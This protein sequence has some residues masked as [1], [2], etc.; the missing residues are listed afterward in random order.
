MDLCRLNRLLALIFMASVAAGCHADQ[1]NSGWSL[2][3]RM[4]A[5]DRLQR[6]GEVP[7]G[8]AYGTA[9]SPQ[10][11]IGV[12]DNKLLV[13]RDY[14]NA[15]ILAVDPAT[16]D[17]EV[18]EGVP[19][20]WDGEPLILG[21]YK[22]SAGGEWVWGDVGVALYRPDSAASWREAS[23]GFVKIE[24]VDGELFALGASEQWRACAPEPPIVY[25]HTLYRHEGGDRWTALREDV[26]AFSVVEEHLFIT[27]PSETGR[28]VLMS[29]DAGAHWTPSSNEFALFPANVI[30]YDEGFALNDE[31]NIWLSDNGTDWQPVERPEGISNLVN[32]KA[33]PFGQMIW[34]WPSVHHDPM[35]LL[36][37]VDGQLMPFPHPPPGFNT[38]GPLA[39]AGGRLAVL[40]HWNGLR[41]SDATSETW[42][43]VPL[44]LGNIRC[45]AQHDET[46]F[47]GTFGNLYR[48]NDLHTGA[49]Q[50]LPFVGVMNCPTVTEAGLITDTPDHPDAPDDNMFYLSRYDAGQ[51]QLLEPPL[52]FP[53]IRRDGVRFHC[54]NWGKVTR[55]E[56]DGSAEPIARLGT[57]SH[58]CRVFAAN[59]E[60]LLVSHNG[61]FSI[62]ALDGGE[63][64]DAN[65]GLPTVG[66]E[67]ALY[68][69]AFYDTETGL[70]LEVGRFSEHLFKWSPNTQRWESMAL[71]GQF[72][73]LEHRTFAASQTTIYTA[74]PDGIWRLDQDDWTRVLDL[75]GEVF[76]LSTLNAW[77]DE[78]FFS[79]DHFQVY[80]FD[81]AGE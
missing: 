7:T 77:N 26:S 17:W 64:T 45:L 79:T 1:D 76:A 54:D 41:I 52:Q 2:Y 75:R 30:R 68:F 63:V 67:E 27:V 58:P 13:Q 44:A 5:D 46:F 28:Q 14:T 32:L 57:E 47:A 69:R 35:I 22:R 39:T 10:D 53:Y 3:D 59:E 72:E 16:G 23:I 33:T 70:F 51:W 71:P 78:L 15:E 48:I 80:R 49:W 37:L 38:F 56:L 25:E 36:Q 34:S 8:N 81:P 19:N 40:N 74:T 62:M 43:A 66:D 65:A 18:L 6:L 55:Y 24:E 21:G 9:C 31:H 20:E 60:R 12:L 4:P 29:E 73:G 61:K 50:S 42:H 11:F